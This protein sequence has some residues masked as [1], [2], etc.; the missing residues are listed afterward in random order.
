MQKHMRSVQE[1]KKHFDI[2]LDR[3][4]VKYILKANRFNEAASLYQCMEFER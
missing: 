3:Q 2:K 4:D 1:L